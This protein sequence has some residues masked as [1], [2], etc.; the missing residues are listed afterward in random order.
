MT[1]RYN[2]PPTNLRG[3]R[4]RLTAVAKREG[5]VFGRLQQHIG[6]LVVSQFFSPLIDDRGNPLLLVKGGVS[7]E[8]R[9][10]IPES[11]TSKDL[12]LVVRGDLNLVH[13]R[14]AD[15]GINGWAG[16]TA[17]FTPPVP[18]EVATLASSS[19]RFTAKVAYRS[20]PFVSVPGTCAGAGIR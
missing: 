20:R 16:F 18:F 5:I 2:A 17:G 19:H 1:S 9:R 15:S 12:D 6:V 14:L 3:L 11:R 4:D 7:L 13:D 10:G 8:L